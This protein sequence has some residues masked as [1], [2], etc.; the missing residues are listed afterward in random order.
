MNY[1]FD[2]LFRFDTSRLLVLQNAQ[3]YISPITSD[4]SESTLIDSFPIQA[5]T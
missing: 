2:L 1:Q 3:D 5:L 4:I